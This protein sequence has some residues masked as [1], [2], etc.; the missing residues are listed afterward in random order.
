MRVPDFRTEPAQFA[1]HLLRIVSKGGYDLLIPTTDNALTAIAPLYDALAQNIPLGC[2]SPQVTRQVLNKDIALA[3]ARQAGLRIPRSFSASGPFVFPLVAKPAVPEAAGQ[4]KAK[5]FHNSAELNAAIETFPDFHRRFLL[6][7][8]CPGD[9]VGVEALMHDG[10]PVA[11]FQHR[12]LKELPYSGGVSVTAVAEPLDPE[13]AE[14]S[15]QLLRHLNWEGPA[16][17]EYRYDRATRSAVLMEVNGRYWGSLPLSIAAGVEFPYYH[18]QIVRGRTPV[19][20]A[21]K[22]GKRMRWTAGEIF[23]IR[24]MWNALRRGELARAD[25]L[26]ALGALLKDLFP[27][28]NDAVWSFRDPLPFLAEF[29]PFLHRPGSRPAP[30]AAVEST[31][32]E[33]E[34][35]HASVNAG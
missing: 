4:F 13:L 14:S 32:S 33:K 30:P 10:Q 35:S 1:E 27:G 3:I 5:Y 17:V 20:P 34:S 23:R 8:Y 11:L 25:F 29:A 6:Q 16:M 22:I 7:E 24:G 26:R 21:Y 12:R 31:R 18:W 15:V 9:G 28:V 2:P 19:P